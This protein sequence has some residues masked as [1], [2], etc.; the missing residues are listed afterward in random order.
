[1]ASVAVIGAGLGGLSCAAHLIGAGHDVTIF[2]KESSPGG[3]ARR[4]TKNTSSG[5]YL[6]EI[7]PT[8]FT[9]LD[10]AELPFD[11][12][13]LK[14]AEHV[15]MIPVSPSYRGVFRDG[16]HIDWPHDPNNIF[17]AIENFAGTSQAEGFDDYVKWLEKLV[18][19]EYDNFV[20][21][22]FSSPIDLMDSPGALIKLLQMGAFSKMDKKVSQFISDPRLLS[23]STFQALY[24]GVTPAQ[25]L[26]VYC[27][28][29]YMDLVQGVFYPKGGMSTYGEALADQIASSGATIHYNATVES[30]KQLGRNSIE[31]VS[32]KQGNIFDAVVSNADLPYSF[33]QIFDEEMPKKLKRA[34]YSPSCLIYVVGGKSS[35]QTGGPHHTICFSGDD[36]RSYDELV[37]GKT[38]MTDPSFLISNPNQTDPS[39]SPEGTNVFYVLEPCPHLDSK[40]DFNNLRDMHIERMRGHLVKS[41]VQ[42][43]RIDAEIFIDPLDWD[44]SGMFKGT[45]F[46]L[47]HTFFQ[48][49]PFRPSNEHKKR[50]GVFFCGTGTTPGVGIPM[51]IESGRLASEKVNIYLDKR[52]IK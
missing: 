4:I 33:P 25:A 45:P 15:D 17:E 51:V 12:L 24:A 46:S 39:I 28:I 43:E 14:M 9:M 47:A 13:D 27:I 34:K 6:T 44:N 41:G 48:S 20:A 35:V 10:I 21:K 5:E 31:I 23:M 22:N 26:A 2:E 7:G 36:N 42:L 30:V 1:M 37:S 16:S 50:E 49:G 19:V 3:R 18:K 52:K 32:G 29:S 8:V 11:A 38:M 40:T